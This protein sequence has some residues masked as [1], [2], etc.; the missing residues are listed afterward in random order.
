MR[1]GDDAPPK[2]STC[3]L[4]FN[5]VHLVESTIQSV[6]EQTYSD[7]ELIVSDDRSTDGTYE[8][9]LA[10][11]KDHPK[12][13]IV[14]P[15]KNLGMAG[16]ANFAV[17]HARGEYIALLHHDDIYSP[18]L[19]EA[20]ATLLDRNPSAGFAANSHKNHSTGRVYL[21]PFAECN[22]G[23]DVLRDA[24]LPYWG[25]PVRGTAMVRRSCWE[26][27]GGMREQFG[28]L[29]D[30]DMWMRLSARYDFA[31][32]REPLISVRAER[33][34]YYPEAYWR[35]SWPRHKLTYMLYGT[36]HESFYGRSTLEGHAHQALYRARVNADIVKW[37]GYAIV[38]RRGDILASSDQVG[39]A[40]EYLPVVAARKLLRH[41]SAVFPK[42]A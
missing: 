12:L 22:R 18:R 25:C 39:N 5:H 8:A 17:T 15:P 38:K 32:V 7:F 2:V 28:M 6:L 26:A 41:L 35:W 9:L 30:V 14:Q 13:R 19:L 23:L 20:W 31:Y 37:L 42:N 36:H 11:A 4:T 3:L 29:A 10:L 24:M 40:Y 1:L 33:P 16:N 21:H 34:G 27:V